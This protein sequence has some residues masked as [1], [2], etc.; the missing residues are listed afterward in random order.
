[1]KNPFVTNG[2]AGAE[3]FCDR[4][5]E[6]EILREL[7]LNEN[8][9]ALISPRRI[10]KTD[11]IWHVFD[12]PEIQKNYHCFVVDIYAT[13]NLSDFVNMLGK[14]LVDELRPK[15]RKA[16]EKF[17]NMVASLR[18][19]ITFDISGMPVWGVGIGSINNPTVTLDE[20]F[21]Y[22]EKADK[23]CL[24]A[25]DEFQQITRYGDETIEATIRTYVQRCTNAHFIFSGSQRHMMN[26]MFTSPSRPFYQAVTIMNLQPLDLTV[27]TDF[28]VGKF[29]EE[30]KH[31]DAKV[32]T[33]LYERFEA[34]TSYMHRVMNVLFSRT[35]KG[36]TCDVSMVDEAV[37]FIIRLSSDTYES[38]LYQMP[39][40]QRSLF[41][42]IA[43]E[44]KAKEVTSGAFIKRNKLNSASSVSSALKGLLDKDFIT[45]D[46]NVYSV[47]DQFFALWLKFK[48]LI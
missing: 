47:Y 25:I 4:V 37:E 10:G 32:V 7:L 38:L 13:K 19:E 43:R 45:E 46:K 35:D 30:G 24:V 11:L 29:E 17:V 48:G 34:V 20:I 18:S 8:N 22:L 36:A 1:M 2:Y 15:G 21:T 27:Y 39:E 26:G 16:W 33:L 42:S 14:A 28:C 3:Y 23:P 31:L 5:Q 41:L 12:N 44:G 6:T 40:K 9:I